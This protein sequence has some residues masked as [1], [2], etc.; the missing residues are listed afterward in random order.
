MNRNTMWLV[1]TVGLV[2]GIAA[3][4]GAFAIELDDPNNLDG[5]QRLLI[6]LGII[7]LAVAAGSIGIAWVRDKMGQ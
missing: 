2:L 3:L 6:V 7:G 4:A 1:A 5:L